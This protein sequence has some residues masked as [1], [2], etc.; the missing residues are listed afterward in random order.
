MLL[1]TSDQIIFLEMGC[2]SSTPTRASDQIKVPP[3]QSK[4]T[5]QALADP[6][7]QTVEMKMKQDSR[8]EQED[9]E[10]KESLANSMVRERAGKTPMVAAKVPEDA[11]QV[12]TGGMGMSHSVIES[13]RNVNASLQEQ[14]G[15]VSQLKTNR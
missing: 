4:E 11:S 6:V 2:Q 12:A 14:F 1:I 15:E 13:T 3:V 8:H 9:V 7:V 10:R 5:V